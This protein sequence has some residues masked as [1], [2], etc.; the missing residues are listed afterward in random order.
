[1]E[2]APARIDDDGRSQGAATTLLRFLGAAILLAGLYGGYQ[3]V[4]RAWLLFEKQDTIVRFAEEIDK[5]AHLNGFV[6]QLGVVVDFVNKAKNALPENPPADGGPIPPPP[7]RTAA[8]AGSP[9]E[10]VNASYFVAWILTIVLLGLIAR[11]SMWAITAGGK[12]ALFSINSDHQLRLVIRE[13][14]QEVR[15][16]QI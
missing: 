6:A 1:M 13:L 11:I 15:T 7:T 12:L 4:E 2:N 10:P 9:A 16:R 5:H 14:I 8:Y 3:V